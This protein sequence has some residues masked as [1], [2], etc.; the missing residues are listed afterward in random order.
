MSKFPKVVCVATL[1][2]FIKLV[3]INILNN[4]P[5]MNRSQDHYDTIK[6][7]TFPIHFLCIVICNN[8]NIIFLYTNKEAIETPVPKTQQASLIQYLV[9][10]DMSLKIGGQCCWSL[11]RVIDSI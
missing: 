5:G 4:I 3:G 9:S 7:C 8:N 2:Y 6:L 10:C 11:S 1:I